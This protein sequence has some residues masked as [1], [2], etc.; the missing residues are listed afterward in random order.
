MTDR[1]RV[2][3]VV[4]L[5]LAAGLSK[6]AAAA[7]ACITYRSLARWQ[8]EDDGFAEAV[9]VASGTGR[10]M[11]EESLVEAGKKDWRAAFAAYEAIYLEPRAD[12]R[13]NPCCPPCRPTA[14]EEKP[15]EVLI[16]ET[17]AVIRVFL[18]ASGEGQPMT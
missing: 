15:I 11:Y 7:K 9:E 12:L 4:L 10:A 16:E 2:R 13:R 17:E 18:Q 1:E 3:A 8:A 14:R 6:H 5:A